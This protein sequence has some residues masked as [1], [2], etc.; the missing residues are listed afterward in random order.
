MRL[1][2]F[3]LKSLLIP[4]LFLSTACSD[5]KP[6]GVMPE[7]KMQAVL[8][9]LALA[10]EYVNGYVYYQNPAQ[11][12]AVVNQTLLNEIYKVHDIDKKTFDK[13][14]E[15]YKKNPKILMAMLDSIVAKKSGKP[16]TPTTDPGL[17]APSMPASPQLAPPP[18]SF[19]S[20]PG[21]AASPPPVSVQ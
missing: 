21:E 9:D 19:G 5:G 18:S 13:S 1:Y 14:L 17:G 8:W 15:Y 4:C 3:L 20:R 12:R 11:N 7:E 6:G 10:G 2:N 16:I